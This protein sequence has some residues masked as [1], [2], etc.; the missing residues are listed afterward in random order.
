MQGTTRINLGLEY[1]H[2]FWEIYSYSNRWS[3][4]SIL[5]LPHI[6]WR[7]RNYRSAL[8][9]RSFRL[10]LVSRS[11][12]M[13]ICRQYFE[14]WKKSSLDLFPFS[15]RTLPICLPSPLK[16]LVNLLQSCLQGATT[17]WLKLTTVAGSMHTSFLKSSGKDGCGSTSLHW[18]KGRK[19]LS[20]SGIFK[21]AI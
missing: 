17:P 6:W 2:W 16:I 9:E 12:M 8:W 20:A 13:S 4:N 10:C 19:S 21:L 1:W 3:R 18:D 14:L 7:C 11:W 5:Q 15:W